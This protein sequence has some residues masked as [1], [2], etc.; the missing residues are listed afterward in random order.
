[1][2]K[3]HSREPEL[4]RLHVDELQRLVLRSMD[5][6]FAMIKQSRRHSDG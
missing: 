5:V 2:A 1:M 3:E 4:G 6:C